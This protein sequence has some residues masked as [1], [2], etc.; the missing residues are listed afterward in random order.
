MNTDQLDDNVQD[1]TTV[2]SFKMH[3]VI[4]W[5]YKPQDKSKTSPPF[6]KTNHQY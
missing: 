4:H 2:N 5:P 6:H 3:E 1:Q